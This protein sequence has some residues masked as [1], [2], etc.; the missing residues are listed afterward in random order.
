M[1]DKK[2]TVVLLREQYKDGLEFWPMGTTNLVPVDHKTARV[3]RRVDRW[4]PGV[5]KLEINGYVIL[6]VPV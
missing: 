4:G 3:L 1:D 5:E 6:V 2:R